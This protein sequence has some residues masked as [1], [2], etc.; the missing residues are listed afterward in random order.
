MAAQVNRWRATVVALVLTFGIDVAVHDVVVA[1]EYVLTPALP[2]VF[3]CAERAPVVVIPVAFADGFG[4]RHDYARKYQNATAWMQRCMTLSVMIMSHTD[5][6]G[7]LSA[8]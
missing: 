3:A 4:C 5:I 7:H 6:A 1:G 2:A 8:W